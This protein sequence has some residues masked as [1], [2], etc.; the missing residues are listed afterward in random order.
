[1]S[2]GGKGGSQTVK[3]ELPK[4]LDTAAQN[5]VGRSQDIA[6]IGFMPY[7]G[8]DVAAFSPMQSAAFQ[9]TKRKALAEAVSFRFAPGLRPGAPV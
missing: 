9:N 3:T 5:A 7:R 2:G 8:P 1:M 4:W 6:E